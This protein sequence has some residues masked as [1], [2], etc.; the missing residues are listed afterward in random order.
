MSD[1]LLYIC[2]FL[3][4]KEK[5]NF[6]S[7]SKYNYSLINKIYFD[8]EMYISQIINISYYNQFR[9]II[10]YYYISLL[11]QVGLPKSVTHLYI[12]CDFYEILEEGLLPNSITHL[13]FG[14]K[15]NQEIIQGNISLIPNSVTHLTFGKIFNRKIIKG[16]IPNSIVELKFS[17][18]FNRKISKDALPKHLIQHNMWR[19]IYI[20]K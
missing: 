10:I 1:T 15:F 5:I 7:T 17:C 13:T 11:K 14:N 20:T 4:I 8:N 16:A 19:N 18:G 9:N 12:E 3:E 2:D 6:L